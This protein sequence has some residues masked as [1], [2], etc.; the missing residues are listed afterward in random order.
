MKNLKQTK[1]KLKIK[2]LK[3]FE[4]ESQ[5][6]FLEKFFSLSFGLFMIIK[7][8]KI[9]TNETRLNTI[10]KLFLVKTPKH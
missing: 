7:I 1:M 3:K 6:N 2:I 10:L 8:V 4:K 9:K 5:R